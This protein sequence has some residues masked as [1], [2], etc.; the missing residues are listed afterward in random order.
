[1]DKY[2][3][4][5]I[6]I[7]E[8]RGIPYVDLY[9]ASGLRPWNADFRVEYYKENGVQDD[10]THPNSKGHKWIYPMIK[11]FIKQHLV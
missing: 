6:S 1:M 2:V 5:L 10:G 11:Q 4:K 7:C 8:R 9:H 3:G